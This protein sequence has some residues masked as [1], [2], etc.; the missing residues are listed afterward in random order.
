MIKYSCGNAAVCCVQT[1]NSAM[2]CQGL[3]I[4]TYPMVTRLEGWT[5]GGYGS[6]KSSARGVRA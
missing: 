1:A 6:D 2:M 5:V 3:D 4:N